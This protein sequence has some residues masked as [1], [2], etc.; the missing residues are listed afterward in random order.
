VLV[1]W[2]PV[3][4]EEFSTEGTGE[5]VIFPAHI[6][7]GFGVLASDFLR[8]LLH[9]Y[10]IELV[11]LTPNSIMIISTFV[12][13][14][15]AYLGITPHFHLWHH[16]FE[17]KKTSKGVVVGSIGFMLRRNMKLEYID[18]TLPDNTTR[19]KQGCSTLTTPRRR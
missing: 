5:T 3:A 10:C 6:E 12:H 1:G 14:C 11:H 2:R 9:F 17:L 13:L 8:E 19:W 16:F 15:E 18:L 4:G 7:R